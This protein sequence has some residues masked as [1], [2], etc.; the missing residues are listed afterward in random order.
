[1][2]VLSLRAGIISLPLGSG[3]TG[4][5]EHRG[6][7]KVIGVVVVQRSLT[8]E[9]PVSMLHKTPLEASL[10][11]KGV[12]PRHS[13]RWCGLALHYGKRRTPVV[14][15]VADDNH[16]HLFRIRYPDEAAYGHA[17]LLLMPPLADAA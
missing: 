13:F 6:R 16:P 12:L 3:T 14:T 1:M 7:Q 5:R 8:K 15:L 17:R 11:I 2:P 10:C 9:T 4:Q